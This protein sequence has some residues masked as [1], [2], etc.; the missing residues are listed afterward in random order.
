MAY[1][2][3]LDH[4][5]LVAA[6]AAAAGSGRGKRRGVGHGHVRNISVS[7]VGSSVASLYEDAGDSDS[8]DDGEHET[9]SERDDLE[10]VHS[11][12][13]GGNGDCDTTP[14]KNVAVERRVSSI[15]GARECASP[16]RSAQFYALAAQEKDVGG[17]LVVRQ[18]QDTDYNYG[19]LGLLGQLTTVGKLDKPFFNARLKALKASQRQLMYVVEDRENG[20]KVVACGTS[21]PASMHV[22]TYALSTLRSNDD[23]PILN[24]TP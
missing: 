19:F 21:Q 6:A 3:Q 13:S 5:A 14:T 2:S 11:G 4:T 8:D 23:N 20:G 16:S 10:D 22:R 1:F 18:L 9:Q 24:P 7:S 15:D 17:G 12:N